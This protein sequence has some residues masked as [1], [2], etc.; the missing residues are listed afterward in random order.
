MGIIYCYTNKEN[1]KQY[2]GQTINE[3]QR[4]ANHFHEAMNHKTEYYFH[5]AIRKYGWDAFEYEVL[6]ETDNLIERETYYIRK[7]NTLRPNGYNALEAHGMTDEVRE[8][9]SKTKKKRF[10]KMTEEERKELTRKMSEANVGS[11]RS[12]ETRRKQSEAMKKYLA[13]NPRPKRVWTQ[14]MRDKQSSLMKEKYKQGIGRW[15]KK[16]GR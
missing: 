12:D 4:K 9:I 13:E 14:E 1:G 15:A 7:L 10:S 16:K 2:V 6:E 3:S 5:R 8:K 11:K